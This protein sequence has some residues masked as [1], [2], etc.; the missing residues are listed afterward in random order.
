MELKKNNAA[1]QTKWYHFIVAFLVGVF[2]T[3]VLPH[4]IKG[5]TGSYFPTPFANPPGKG[6][7]PPILN[8]TWACINLLLASSIF[9]FAKIGQRKKTI[10][11]GILIGSLCMAFYLANYF[12][13]L[14]NS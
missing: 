14:L 12:G 1:L 6:L 3:N 10:W 2:G 5:I 13:R 8:V 9:Y 4:F 7:S 11:I